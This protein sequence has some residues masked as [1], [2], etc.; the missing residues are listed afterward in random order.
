MCEFCFSYLQSLCHILV[1]VHVYIRQTTLN[2]SRRI[3]FGLFLF[4]S[5]SSGVAVVKLQACG[6]K[7]PGIEPRS[8]HYDIMHAKIVCI[9]CFQVAI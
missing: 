2:T 1:H 3:F 8:P 6:K 7:G 5:G 9:S 4:K